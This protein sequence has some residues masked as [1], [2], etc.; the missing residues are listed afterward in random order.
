[1]GVSVQGDG[2]KMSITNYLFFFIGMVCLTPP[3]TPLGIIILL[4]TYKCAQ[5]D[6]EKKQRQRRH[7][8]QNAGYEVIK[9]PDG[10]GWSDSMEPGW[11]SKKWRQQE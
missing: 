8:A 1:M 2:A 3:M 9:V 4:S 10:G 5:E 11:N 6:E 7:A